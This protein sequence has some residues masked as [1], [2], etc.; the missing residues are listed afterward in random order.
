MA[1]VLTTVEVF[2]LNTHQSKVPAHLP[3]AKQSLFL[4]N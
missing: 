1:G 3:P 2:D 4:E